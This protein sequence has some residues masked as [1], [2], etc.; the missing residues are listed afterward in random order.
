M[1]RFIA[2]TV[3]IAALIAIAA[4][5][6]EPASKAEAPPRIRIAHTTIPNFADIPAVLMTRALASAGYDVAIT[7]FA[8]A[9]LAAEA[10]A[11]GDMDVGFGGLS[12]YW[13]AAARGA[14]IVAV[15]EQARG[16]HVLV[17]AGPL[18]E[19]AALA[20]QRLGVNNLGATGGTLVEA[21]VAEACPG[22]RPQMLVMPG[23]T[24]RAAAFV[25]GGLDAA[26]L[27]REDYIDLARRTPE[28][29]GL[30][31]DFSTRW[32]LA[33]AGVL[34][35]VRFA[36]ASPEIVQDLVGGYLSA[37]RAVVDDPARLAAAATDI[38]GDGRDWRPVAEAFVSANTWPAD[39]G[40]EPAVIRDTIA[41]LVQAGNLPGDVD[42]GRLIDRSYL[43]RSLGRSGVPTPSPSPQ[44]E[45]H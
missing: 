12:T 5:D 22:T 2:S 28:R 43:D 25:S 32:T 23:A 13:A 34:V 14:P 33:T 31:E 42:P 16:V 45:L 36:E 30:V 3:A 8:H 20:G 39:G 1:T 37:I 19:C 15:A 17:A 40:L 24:T 29:I 26:V 44:A 4:C 35:N 21:Y 9:S 41:F 10:L 27:M 11:R 6:A 7:A 18:R 38:L